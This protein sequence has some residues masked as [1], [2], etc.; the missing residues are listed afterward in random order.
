MTR[1]GDAGPAPAQVVGGDKDG[2]SLGPSNRPRRAPVNAAMWKKDRRNVLDHARERAWEYASKT[3][4]SWEPLDLQ[5]RKGMP[6]GVVRVYN[7]LVA[8][9]HR[10]ALRSAYFRIDYERIAEAAASAKSMA[11][12]WVQRAD[13]IGVLVIHDR[14]TWRTK[15]IRGQCTQL[16]LVCQS[17]TPEQVRGLHA[18]PGSI[19]SNLSAIEAESR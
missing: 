7:T 11:Y 18:I 15:G 1:R 5:I 14:G 19:S 17:E 9:V 12:R 8:F 6:R 13:E 16:G 2:P 4:Y 3:P 10:K